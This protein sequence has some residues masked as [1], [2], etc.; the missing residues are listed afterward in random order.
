MHAKLHISILLMV[1]LFSTVLHAKPRWGFFFNIA[2]ATQTL[3]QA[4]STPSGVAS[5]NRTLAKMRHYGANTWR[6]FVEIDELLS[7]A[8]TVNETAMAL[9][10]KAFVMASKHNIQ[11]LFSGNVLFHWQTAAKWILDADDKVCVCV[12][13]FVCMCVRVCVCLCHSLVFIRPHSKPMLTSG[14]LLHHASANMTIFLLLTYKTR[15]AFVVAQR[16]LLDTNN[17]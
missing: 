13:G 10:E 2:N 14:Q 12:C 9:V 8:N 3:T 5:V 7:D 16:G 6:M 1:V 4:L 17:I 15:Y 11:V